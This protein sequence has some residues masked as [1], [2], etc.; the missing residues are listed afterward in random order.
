MSSKSF[1]LNRSNYTEHVEKAAGNFEVRNPSAVFLKT[2]YFL[3]V[4]YF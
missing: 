2:F 4:E 3:L 1:D